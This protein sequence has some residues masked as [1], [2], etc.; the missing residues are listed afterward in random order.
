MSDFLVIGGGVLGLLTARELAAEGATV[1]LLEKGECGREASWAGGGIVS[2]LYPWRYSEPVTALAQEA[3]RAYPALAESLLNETGIDPEWEQSGLLMLDADD[4][5]EALVW[6]Q[7]VGGR[8]E[9]LQEEQIYAREPALAQGFEQGLWMPAIANIRNPRLLKSLLASLRANPR[10]RLVERAS[11]TDFILSP[12]GD[13]VSGLVVDQQG[14]SLQFSAQRIIVT[15]GAWSAGL[16]RALSVELPVEPVK[17]QMLLYRPEKPLL[18]SIVL[19]EGR[20]L[21][22]RRDGHLLA[23]STLEHSGF[24]KSTS[25]EALRSLQASAQALLPALA[26]TPVLRQWAGLRPGA[27]QGVPFIGAVPGLRNLYINAGQYRNG[28]VL[29]PASVGLMLDILLAR[30]PRVDPRP[31]DP[32]LRQR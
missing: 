13:T 19:T 29:A 6:A 27:P 14:Q 15:A 24:D 5:A 18:T 21:I 25:D 1:T 26:S 9:A 11:V 7:R 23:G 30:S 31:Y 10:V 4:A 32:A 28:L 22:P 2:P 3:Q 17:G 8:M 16:L 20:Y 12:G